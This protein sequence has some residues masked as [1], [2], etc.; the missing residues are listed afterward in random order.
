MGEWRGGETVS[1]VKEVKEVD[2]KEVEVEVEEVG[3]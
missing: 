3:E 2:V 1:I